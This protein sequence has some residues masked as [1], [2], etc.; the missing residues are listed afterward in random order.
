MKENTKL[1]IPLN[2]NEDVFTLFSIF[3]QFDLRNAIIEVDLASLIKE[4]QDSLKAKLTT[5]N[6]SYSEK[7]DNDD[8]E[9]E[10]DEVPDEENGELNLSNS[11]FSVAGVNMPEKAED[12]KS[13]E[14]V[15]LFHI[16]S[17][18]RQKARLVEVAEKFQVKIDLVDKK[19]S[20][21][22]AAKDCK[23]VH[24]ELNKIC[25]KTS[26][27]MSI[28][29]ARCLKNTN[30]VRSLVKRYPE[31]K[32][33]FISEGP[34]KARLIV[35]G[36]KEDEC[37]GC[38]EKLNKV[39]N[40]VIVLLEITKEYEI[41][42]ELNE[43]LKYLQDKYQKKYEETFKKKG[44]ICEIGKIEAKRPSRHVIYFFVKC[45]EEHFAKIREY[46]IKEIRALCILNVYPKRNVKLMLEKPEG[47]LDDKV[48][49][50]PLKNGHYLILGKEKNLKTH[51]KTLFTQSTLERDV[52][53][54]RL[55]IR[56][57]AR[58]DSKSISLETTEISPKPDQYFYLFL[59]VVPKI[60]CILDLLA[61]F[62]K[63]LSEANTR[64][65]LDQSQ[66]N[67]TRDIS[68]DLSSL[69]E[70]KTDDSSLLRQ[71]L[72]DSEIQPKNNDR[73][74]TQDKTPSKDK[75]SIQDKIPIQTIIENGRKQ[76]NLPPYGELSR[77]KTFFML[78]DSEEIS[79][80]SVDVDSSEYE[81]LSRL[82]KQACPSIQLKDINKILNPNL[83]KPYVNKRRQYNQNEV[84]E[85]ILFY[86]SEEEPDLEKEGKDASLIE[87]DLLEYFN[88]MQHKY[89]KNEDTNVIMGYIALFNKSDNKI[90]SYY[91]AYCIEFGYDV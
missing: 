31:T 52:D 60:K 72:N 11:G 34:D 47:I 42:G 85:Y 33:R 65:D 88:P 50:T 30:Y 45:N 90:I 44:I 57:L 5:M 58:V 87:N 59:I 74:P 78:D 83:W 26:E 1:K 38:L 89:Y 53:L 82:L 29:E 27:Y 10:Q 62:D 79:V 91:P 4:K 63:F 64:N 66:L 23:N 7:Q 84:Y 15:L 6:V 20:I 86:Q 70:T 51:L 28:N 76:E 25:R 40:R 14:D 71:V 77:N 24:D 43:I 36:K 12:S 73:V 22:G 55:R 68:R 39:M 48:Y 2:I 19:I 37:K 35:F 3:L 54:F 75:V 9:E 81:R 69:E 8:D 41:E 56:K 32:L 18:R 16:L 49:V 61:K 80:E 17:S 46:M 13:I 67:I 21:S